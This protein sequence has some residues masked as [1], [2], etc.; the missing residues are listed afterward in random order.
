M[1]GFVGRAVVGL[2]ALGR[3]AAAAGVLEASWDAPTRVPS[4]TM[5][6]PQEGNEAGRVEPI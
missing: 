4:V 3:A 2:S 6:S 1:F 5:A